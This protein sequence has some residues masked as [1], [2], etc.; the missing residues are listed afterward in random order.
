[1]LLIQFIV[2]AGEIGADNVNRRTKI[3]ALITVLLIRF[4]YVRFR[5]YKK[6]TLE[7]SN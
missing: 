1:M 4:A 2:I 3:V 7:D 6:N 5:K